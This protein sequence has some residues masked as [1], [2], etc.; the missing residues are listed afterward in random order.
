MRQVGQQ[1]RRVGSIDV[2]T[3]TANMVAAAAKRT[4]I[5]KTGDTF[6]DQSV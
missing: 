6:N 1:G 4:N 2:P 5:D 3:L